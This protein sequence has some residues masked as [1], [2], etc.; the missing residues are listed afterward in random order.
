M[1]W[2]IMTV[3]LQFLVLMIWRTEVPLRIVYDGHMVTPVVEVYVNGQKVE[4][5]FDSGSSGL[6]ML[7]GALKDGATDSIGVRT[8]DDYGVGERMLG[9]RGRVVAANLRMG[10]LSSDQPIRIM[11]IDSARYGGPGV[12]WGST[13]DSAR[14]ESNHFRSLS[15]IMGV[16]MRLKNDGS[17]VANPLAQLPGNGKYIIRFPHFGGTKGKLIINPDSADVEGFILFKLEKGKAQLPNGDSSW[18]DNQLSGCVIVNG[19]SD[20]QHTLL[21][22]GTP[23]VHVYSKD[24][25]ETV[26]VG[27]GNHVTLVVDGGSESVTTSFLVGRERQDGKDFVYLDEVK[28]AG[29]NI[30][31]TRFFFDFDVL[32]DQVNGVIGVR[33]K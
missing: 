18:L 16:G 15:A 33:R 10:G 2:L 1:G 27:G 4:A 28:G 23:D 5:I 3:Y 7:G 17:G 30:F 26:S 13:G 32:Y 14:I 19:G 12:L 20:C 25:S 29:K 22:T 21:D 31:G 9:V 24:F 6:R 8:S 11:C